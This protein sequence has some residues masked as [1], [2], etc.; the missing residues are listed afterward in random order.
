MHHILCENPFTSRDF[1][2]RPLI[3]WHILG[4]YLLLMWPVGVVEIAFN[5]GTLIP[6]KKSTVP[7]R[8][9]RNFGHLLHTVPNGVGQILG[10]GL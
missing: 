4:S 8:S 5:L 9:S 1:D 6:L 10:L 2:I 7:W 3:L